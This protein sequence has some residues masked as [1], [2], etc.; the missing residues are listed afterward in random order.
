MRCH[1]AVSCRYRFVRNIEG[2]MS[3]LG[4]VDTIF[5]MIDFEN[6]TDEFNHIFRH[7]SSAWGSN[8]V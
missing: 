6:A 5:S 8:V 2:A 4:E 1:M 3:K 7:E